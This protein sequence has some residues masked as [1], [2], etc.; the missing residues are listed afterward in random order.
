L[1]EF[2]RKVLLCDSQLWDF[3]Y[4]VILV[5][6]PKTDNVDWLVV[7]FEVT[8]GFDIFVGLIILWRPKVIQTVSRKWQRSARVDD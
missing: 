6:H 5:H 1:G 7:A 3:H 4:W 8:C 2:E